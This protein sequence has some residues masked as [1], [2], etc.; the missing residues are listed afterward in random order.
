MNLVLADCE[1]F[2]KIRAKKTGGDQREEKRVLGFVLLRGENIVSLTVEGPPPP[3]EGVVKLP[4]AS[5]L[6]GIGLGRA[7]GR[8]I[9]HPAVIGTSTAA[10]GAAAPG[11]SGP[12]R[13]VGGP[14]AGLMTPAG[15]GL[16]IPGSVPGAI[17]GAAIP[18][19]NLAGARLPGGLIPG[20]PLPPNFPIGR[21]QPT[22]GVPPSMMR[23]PRPNGGQ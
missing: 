1:E 17:P 19:P 8:G 7:A 2:R 20:M 21:G 12:V 16:P 14:A 4:I 18:P 10:M 23:G 22:I 6:P 5:S 9:A 13:G 3:E 15:R 11:L